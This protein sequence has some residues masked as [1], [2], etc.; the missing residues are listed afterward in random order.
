MYTAPKSY[1]SPKKVVH[2]EKARVAINNFSFCVGDRVYPF[3]VIS[4][5]GVSKINPNRKPGIVLITVGASLALIALFTSSYILASV[6]LVLC[7][8]GLIAIFLASERYAIRIRMGTEEM[9]ALISSEK[10]YVKA[11]VDSINKEIKR[12]SYE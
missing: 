6:G 7:I 8:S 9:D 10:S 11:I 1:Y 4:K 12:T 3:N 2:D 5:F